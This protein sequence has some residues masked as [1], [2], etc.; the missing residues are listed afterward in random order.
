M[1]PP[2]KFEKSQIAPCGM[3]CGTCLAYLRE[4]NKCPGCRVISSDK[5]VSVRRCIITK[6]NHLE[7]TKSKFCYECEKFPCLRIKQLDKRYKTKYR[8]SFIENLL[9]IKENGIANF[10]KFES[11]RRSC[12]NCGSTICVHRTYCI[13]C[14][15]DLIK[16]RHHENFGN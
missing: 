15:I 12:P 13:E 8:T 6:C 3:N 4:K 14:K 16:Y 7:K 10:L 9:M 11:V 1:R 5:A 2:I